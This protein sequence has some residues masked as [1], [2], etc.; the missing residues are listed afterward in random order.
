MMQIRAR[1]LV[2][3]M[4]SFVVPGLRSSHRAEIAGTASSRYCYTVFLRQFSHLARF[5]GG[6]LPR[7]IVELGPGHSLGTAIAGVIAGAE[8]CIGLDLQNHSRPEENLRIFDELV[9]LFRARTPVPREIPIATEPADWGFPPAL[10][11]GL[12]RALDDRR[13]ARIRRDIE[14]GTGEHVAFEAPWSDRATLA[15]DSVD[16]LFSN[17][18]MEHVDDVDAVYDHAQTWLAA[19]GFMTHEI[20]FSS[21]RLTRHWNGHWAIDPAAWRLIRGARPY[22]INR[23]A[24]A[25]QLEAMRRHGF[26]VLDEIPTDR[27]DGL[28]RQDFVDPYALMSEA[29]ARTHFAFVVCQK[30]AQPARGDQAAS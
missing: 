23:H 18:V 4:L 9:A 25:G 2:K 28:Q 10:E 29:D 8:R 19:D 30:P 15:A 17:A 11:A 26:T 3:G 14:T 7:V 27:D 13:L 5:N 12:E 22:L 1:P 16:W 21:H 20:D 24:L 6:R